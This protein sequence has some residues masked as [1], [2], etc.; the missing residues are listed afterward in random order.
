MIVKNILRSYRPTD[1]MVLKYDTDYELTITRIW[2]GLFK[3]SKKITMNLDDQC[4]QKAFFD[5]WDELI[6]TQR[7]INL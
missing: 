6:Q 7:H 2:F 3:T 5:L 1:G 4:N